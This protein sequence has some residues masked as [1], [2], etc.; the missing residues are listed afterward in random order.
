MSI[1]FRP[2]PAM[3]PDA[4]KTYQITQPKTAHTRIGTC[5]QAGCEA[6]ERGWKTVVPKNSPQEAYIRNDSSRRFWETVENGYDGLCTFNFYP[7]QQCF[8]QHHVLDRPQFFI[9]KNG[10]YRR[11]SLA[12][13]H[14]NGADW[15]DDFGEHQER[16]KEQIE[17]G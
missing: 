1:P 5:E 14:R 11:S 10:D 15:V 7:G 12:R 13:R 4:Y 9:V 17:R 6:Y 2:E 16:L 3:S 8:T